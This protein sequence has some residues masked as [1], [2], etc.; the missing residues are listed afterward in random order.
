MRKTW[1]LI[2][3]LVIALAGSVIYYQLTREQPTRIR[4]LCAGSLLYPLERVA[5]AYMSEHSFVTVEVE[6]HGSIQVVRHITELEDSADILMVADY[7]LIPLMMYNVTEPVSKRAYSDWYIRFSGNSIVLAYT[8]SSRYAG[9][10]NSDNWYEVL[11]R[12]G[13]KYGVPN[14]LIDAL[15]YRALM[16]LQL[17]EKYYGEP[18]LFEKLYGF[19]FNPQFETVQIPEKTVIFVPEVQTPSNSKVT[20]RAS[21]IQ[22]A[23]L[24]DS[25]SLD[26]CILYESNAKQYGYNYIVLPEMIDLGSEGMADNYA[27]VEVRFLHARYGSIELKRPGRV[28]HYGLTIPVNALNQAG[29]ESFIAYLLKGEGKN[30]FNSLW[31]PIYDQV[32]SDNSQNT[33]E[34]LRSLVVDE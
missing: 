2:G 30:V 20:L 17:A 12:E 13:V 18:A 23:P 8:D 28:I 15:G 19:N 25:G 3:V 1:L 14:P 21:S 26:Y 16:T 33:P 24:L 27:K 7:S 22:L 9:E 34:A 11:G 31:H 32:Y 29:A 5:E 6:G 10:V 4:I